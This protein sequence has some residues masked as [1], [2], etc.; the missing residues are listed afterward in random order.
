[1]G[2][3]FRR[4]SFLAGV[5]GVSGGLGFP[6]IMRA[7]A[8]GRVVVVGGGAGGLTAARTIAE[9]G[10]GRLRVTLVEANPHYVSC[11][12]SNL[13][14]GGLRGL[15]SITHDYTALARMPD[16]NMIVDRAIE[17]DP[18]S[19]QVELAGGERLRYD[20]LVLSPGID[21]VA[22][23]IAG[24][25]VAAMH[26]MPHA[27]R[28]H[29]GGQ[30]ALLKAQLSAMDDGGVFVIAP[31]PAPYRC[32][33]APYERACLVANYFRTAKPRAKILI[34]D[35]KNSHAK[36][37][38][39]QEAWGDYYPGMVEWVPAEFGGRVTAVNAPAMTLTTED[40]IHHA[41]VANVIPPQTAGAIAHRAGLT[42]ATGWCP[43]RPSTMESRAMDDIYVIGDAANAGDMPKSAVAAAS[44][45]GVAAAAI[46]HRLAGASAR[47]AH[48]FNTCWSTL[49][50]DDA[51]QAGAHYDVQ[52]GAIHRT[53][54]WLS[55]TGE[56]AA[57]RRAMQDDADAWHQR[58]VA[59]LFG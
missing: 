27:W 23:S 40:D 41:D 39:F 5:A 6:R 4:R 10:A 1:M 50:P 38:L 29:G 12:R 51:V 58:F 14:I 32:P 19:R 18:I 30:A 20:A 17:V 22:G 43:V 37:S 52:D 42:D 11:F 34:L 7:G 44:Q 13:Y 57:H 28:A 49:A 36:Q 47:S 46:L 48:F 2:P 35:A 53:D 16:L 3:G 59:G 54:A 24:Y 9:G 26:A 15:T 56:D 31:P 33:P 55:E 8:Q 45:A 25:D 21:F